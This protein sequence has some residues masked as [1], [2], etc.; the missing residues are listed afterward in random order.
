MY[1]PVADSCVT[2]LSPKYKLKNSFDLSD[3]EEDTTRITFNES[4]ENAPEKPPRRHKF[5]KLKTQN[6]LEDNHN[7]HTSY[8]KMGSGKGD[9]CINIDHIHLESERNYKNKFQAIGVQ[10]SPLVPYRLRFWPVRASYVKC[11]EESS[12]KDKIKFCFKTLSQWF[13]SQV[14]LTLI[15]IM[16]ALLGAAAF[17]KTEGP[18]ETE[19]SEELKRMQTDLSVELAT[20]L[21]QVSEHDEAFAK[22]V[23]KY[24]EKHEKMLLEAVSAGYGEGGGGRIWT[25]PGCILF[26]VSLLTTLGF[27]APVPRTPL[28]RGTAVLFSAIG[29]PLHFLLILNIGNLVAIKLQHLSKRKTSQTTSTLH[30]WWLKWFPLFAIATYYTSGVILFGIVRNRNI[31]DSLMFPL[32]FTAAGGV[33]KTSAHVRVLYALYLEIAVTLAAVVVS[34]LQVTATRG[35]VDIGLRL[36]LL[37]NT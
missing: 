13:L 27:G 16:W 12:A 29:I 6:S 23:Q 34:L 36:G 3:A 14:G 11:P 15:L 28:G 30:A 24:M 1:E 8:E 33:A 21:R 19:Q 10:T 25:Y 17:Y 18:R 31:V 32:D 2:I 7:Y 5:Q 20:S 9:N 26:A 37:T 4:S 35:F 22:T